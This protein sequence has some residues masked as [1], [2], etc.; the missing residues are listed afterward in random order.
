ML[1]RAWRGCS[2]CLLAEPGVVKGFS[3][4]DALARVHVHTR[5]YQILQLL[6]SLTPVY[7]TEGDGAAAVLVVA[8]GRWL[9]GCRHFVQHHAEAEH[10]N[11]LVHLALA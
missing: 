3:R 6:V 5:L 11:R 9:V 10:V 1:T 4:C 8:H 7:V 2:V